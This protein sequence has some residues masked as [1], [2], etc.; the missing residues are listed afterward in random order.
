MLALLPPEETWITPL[1]GIKPVSLAEV[2][3]VNENPS[4][5]PNRKAQLFL[6]PSQVSRAT[7]FI[8]GNL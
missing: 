4:V 7:H 8:P 3:R 1:P 5:V 6:E 2:W